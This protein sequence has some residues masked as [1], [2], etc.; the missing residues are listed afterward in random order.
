MWM[1]SMGREIGGPEHAANMIAGKGVSLILKDIAVR[2]RRPVLYPDT[3]SDHFRSEWNLKEMTLT[4]RFLKCNSCS[5][6]I[7]HTTLTRHISHAQL[8]YG[9]T[10]KEL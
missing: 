6:P 7:G 2:F 1:Q 5:S 4:S 3:V 8:L 10:L 9:R